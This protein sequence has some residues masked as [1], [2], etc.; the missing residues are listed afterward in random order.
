MKSVDYIEGAKEG[1]QEGYDAGNDEGWQEGFESAKS[2]N[3]TYIKT[4]QIDTEDTIHGLI[5][6][7]RTIMV[8]CFSK[9]VDD[10]TALYAC[11]LRYAP[12]AAKSINLA[13]LIDNYYESN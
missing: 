2:A 4:T 6:V 3:D 10:P 1:F 8:A 12:T 5:G 11:A 13:N 9:K 7:L